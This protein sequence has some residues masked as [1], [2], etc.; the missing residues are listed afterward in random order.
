MIVVATSMS[1][2]LVDEVE[3]HCFQFVLGHLAVADRDA[4]LGHDLPEPSGELL[5]VVDAVVDE[6]DLPAAVQL[7]QHR[8][9][10]QLGVE[11]RRRGSRRPAGRRAASP[12]WRCRACPAATCAA[13]AEWAWRSSSARPPSAAAL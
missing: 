9:A 10:D 3:H 1:K 2:L 7:A 4:R 6:I 5:D 13:C 11:A 12:D 8:V